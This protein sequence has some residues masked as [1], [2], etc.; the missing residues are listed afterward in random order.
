M[1]LHLVQLPLQEHLKSS[2]HAYETS[3]RQYIKHN[4]RQ[5]ISCANVQVVHN[6]VLAKSAGTVHLCGGILLME[7]FFR[8]SCSFAWVLEDLASPSL[9]QMSLMLYERV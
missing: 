1:H 6:K 7:L 3:E 2:L 9:D 5:I 8:S 4:I